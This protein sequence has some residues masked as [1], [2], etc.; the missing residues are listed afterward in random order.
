MIHTCENA[1][2]D[3]GSKSTKEWKYLRKMSTCISHGNK[4]FVPFSSKFENYCEF[5][6]TWGTT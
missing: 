5:H 4:Y 2:G 6:S 3:I 1:D